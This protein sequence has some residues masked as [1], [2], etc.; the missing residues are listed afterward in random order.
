MSGD[1]TLGTLER[2]L[3]LKKLPTFA[4]LHPADLAPLAACLVPRTMAAGVALPTED[5]GSVYVLLEG[6]VR[7]DGRRRDAP[8]LLG[9]L[10]VLAG[11]RP[12]ERIAEVESST[13]EIRR[14]DLFEILADE[15]EVWL[16]ALRY[17][18]AQAPRSEI[19]GAVRPGA[20]AAAA[21]A[22]SDLA[23]RIASLRRFAPFAGLGVHP[24]GQI[25]SELE[26]VAFEPGDVIW[27][28]EDAAAHLLA[29]AAGAVRCTAGAGPA[30]DVGAGSLLGLTESLCAGRFD[31]RAE[32]RSTVRALRIDVEALVD[33]LEDDPE[34][35][36]ELL[37]VIARGPL[38]A[39]ERE[40]AR[41]ASTPGGVCDEGE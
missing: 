41:P 25:A 28:R 4:E 17:V 33:V 34:A 24:L 22:P 20:A 35:G 38:C 15:F 16:A 32:A 36:V 5:D 6:C 39:G 37:C 23:D 40:S 1:A 11:V 13:L 18:C 7:E 12:A 31:Y 10:D 14:R 26:E 19:P 3:A 8:A 30:R 21:A 9:M 27:Q 29:I 2:V